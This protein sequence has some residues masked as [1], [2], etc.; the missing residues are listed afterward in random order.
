MADVDS[1]QSATGSPSA[2]KRLSRLFAELGAGRA[3]RS[4][5]PAERHALIEARV[6]ATRPI[7]SGVIISGALIL[8]LTGL[9]EGLGLA[10]GIGYPWWVTELV[11]AAIAGCAMAIWH[12]DDWRPR[13]VLTLLSTILLGVF[14]SV[15]IPGVSGQLAIRTGLFQLVP[16][17]LLALLARPLSIFCLVVVMIALASVRV[18]IHGVP[19]TG[20]ALYWLFTATTIAYGLLLGHYITHYAISAHRFR[21]RMRKQAM[22]DEL[23]GLLNRAG[24]NREAAEAYGVATTRGLPLSFAFFDIDFFKVVNDTYGHEAGDG[25]LQM[26]GRILAER[27][28]RNTFEARL[29]GEEFAVMFIDQTPEQVE[30][31]VMRV[32][33]EFAQVA[34]EYSSRVSAGVAHRQPGETMSVHLRRADLALYEAKA[35]GRDRMVVSRV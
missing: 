19:G 14:L 26:L 8:A 31:F 11:A 35:A 9:F 18:A 32:R 1:P 6:S 12:I 4:L 25:V 24:W 28:G 23:T 34:G 17:A 2:D 33:G 20:A 13:L 10:P 27:A 7:V 15:P 22:T 30:G 5:S 29:G 21:S 16:I 3:L